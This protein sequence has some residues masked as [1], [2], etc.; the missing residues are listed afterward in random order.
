M[1]ARQCV[2]P[3]HTRCSEARPL[4]I[5]DGGH[6]TLGWSEFI[7]DYNTPDTVVTGET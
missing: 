1:P 7:G 4:I 3:I 6:V 2:K 5:D